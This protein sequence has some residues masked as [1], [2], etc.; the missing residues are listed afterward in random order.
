M[1][2]PSDFSELF[3]DYSPGEVGLIEQGNIDLNKRPIVYNPDGSFSTVRSKSWNFDGQE[4]LLP[5]VSD[6][7]RNLTDAEAVDLYKRT[8]KHLGKFKSPEAADAY[9]QKL[10][11]AQAAQYERRFQTGF[12]ASESPGY[13]S[14]FFGGEDFFG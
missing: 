4:V 9:A 2:Q 8:G 13:G 11:E 12:P 6:D 14:D 3:P 5:T 1:A 10:H 7:G